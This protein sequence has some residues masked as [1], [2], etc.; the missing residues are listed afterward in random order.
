[1][2]SLFKLQ[3][4]TVTLMVKPKTGVSVVGVHLYSYVQYSLKKENSVKSN[5]LFLLFTFKFVTGP[6]DLV[7][8]IQYP[9]ILY[10]AILQ[11]LDDQCGQITWYSYNFKCPVS[12]VSVW[13]PVR[14]M[15]QRRNHAKF[16]YFRKK[17]PLFAF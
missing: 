3:Q 15:V 8:L 9:E 16:S 17:G 7:I 12:A 2:L 10:K 5:Y 6:S 4:T 11:W 1:M 13:V 14:L